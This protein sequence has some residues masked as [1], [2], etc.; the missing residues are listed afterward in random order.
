MSQA[1]HTLMTGLIDY[2]GLFPPAGLPM[3]EAVGN[4][5]KYRQPGCAGAQALAQDCGAG[6][7]G[8]GVIGE[9][10]FRA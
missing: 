6:F 5:A 1:I 9:H 7:D 10:G 4:Y 2:A 3:R 8:G